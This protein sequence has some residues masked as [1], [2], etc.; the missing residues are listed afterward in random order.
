MTTSFKVYM[1]AFQ[2]GQ[3]RLVDVPTSEISD[4]TEALLSRIFYYGQNDFQPKQGLCSVSMGDII[5]LTDG[6]LYM[7]KP[8]GFAAMSKEAV[9]EYRKC[10]RNERFK[11]QYDI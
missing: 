11:F 5:E 4:D 7:V 1:L 9:E 3:I 8:F 6:L 2:E 10:P